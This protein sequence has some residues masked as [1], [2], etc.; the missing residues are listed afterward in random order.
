M[1]LEMLP[2]YNNKIQALYVIRNVLLKVMH[3]YRLYMLIIHGLCSMVYLDFDI[4]N[5]TN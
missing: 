1:N 4:N 2:T 5:Y 3:V